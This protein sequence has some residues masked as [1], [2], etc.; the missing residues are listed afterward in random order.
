MIEL[1]IE[2]TKH[3]HIDTICSNMRDEDRDELYY[4][5]GNQ[6][7]KDGLN[8]YFYNY[9]STREDEEECRTLFIDN[10]PCAVGG[11]N[12]QFDPPLIW[13]VASKDVD[14]HK[15]TFLRFMKGH[16]ANWKKDFPVLSCLM[17]EGNRSHLYW[18]YKSG[19]EVIS[20]EKYGPY[21]ENFYIIEF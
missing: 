5:I 18:A 9:L 8:T 12:K 20:I 2:P 21:E 4:T 3:E 16:I 1:H 7:H 10:K 17:W 6:N 14:N 15:L 13:L 11:I 19:G